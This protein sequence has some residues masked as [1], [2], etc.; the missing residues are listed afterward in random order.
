M[1]CKNN[2]RILHGNNGDKVSI[3]H[4]PN[5]F[6]FKSFQVIQKENGIKEV[7]GKC[8]NNKKNYSLVAVIYPAIHKTLCLA[9]LVGVFCVYLGSYAYELFN[10]YH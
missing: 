6:K 8:K 9:Y 5:D 10:L 3:R 7:R 2:L 4:N 1:S